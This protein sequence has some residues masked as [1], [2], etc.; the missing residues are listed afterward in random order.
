MKTTLILPDH[1]VRELKRRAARR[2]ETLSAVVA[3]ALR[4]GLAAE[5]P[6]DL[7]PLPTHRMGKPLVDIADRDALY[8]AMEGV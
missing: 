6:T 8:R 4:R 3:E 7:P 1:V 5:E 2:G